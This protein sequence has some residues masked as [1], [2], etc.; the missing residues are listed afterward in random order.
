MTL[1]DVELGL[2]VKI[3]RVGGE[4]AF[5]RRLLELGLLP[6]VQVRVQK[7]APLGDPIEISVRGGSLSIR[8]AEARAIDVEGI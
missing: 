1:A 2:P 4:R 8:A 5:R 6:G 7:V 3:R